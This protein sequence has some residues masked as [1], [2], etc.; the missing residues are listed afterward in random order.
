MVED[1]VSLVAEQGALTIQRFHRQPRRF[2]RETESRSGWTSGQS[3]TTP[4]VRRAVIALKAFVKGRHCRFACSWHV[5]WP[6]IA[7]ED[8]IR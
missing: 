1:Q 3:L 8:E 4:V 2:G 6:D 5:K 7:A